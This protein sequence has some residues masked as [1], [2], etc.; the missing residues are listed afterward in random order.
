[1]TNVYR[2]SDDSI[3][4][5]FIE[6]AGR[7]DFDVLEDGEIPPRINNDRLA[8]AYKRD[9]VARA[10]DLLGTLTPT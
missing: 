6:V 4:I 2:N 8:F 3:R 5:R 1:M 9:A 7:W 10:E